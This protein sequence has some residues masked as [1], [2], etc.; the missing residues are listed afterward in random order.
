MEQHRVGWG[1]GVEERMAEEDV[2]Q[3]KT[4]PGGASRVQRVVRKPQVPT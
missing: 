4:T 3:V 2:I 1:L